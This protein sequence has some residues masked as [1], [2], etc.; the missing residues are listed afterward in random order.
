MSIQEINTYSYRCG[1]CRYFC[2]EE[3]DRER[4]APLGRCL[5]FQKETML[6]PP[7]VKPAGEKVWVLYGRKCPVFEDKLDTP[8]FPPKSSS[9]ALTK[10]EH[11]LWE[12]V[13]KTERRLEVLENDL[14][15]LRGLVT[16][17]I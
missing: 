6:T 7:W 10:K 2:S 13:V 4:P 5:Y 11:R 1:D 12:R 17:V 3:L 8:E 15:A 16:P 14:E 9:M